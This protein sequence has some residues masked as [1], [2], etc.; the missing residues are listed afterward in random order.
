MKVNKIDQYSKILFFFRGS[1]PLK[2]GRQCK[3]GLGGASK[4]P[5]F[6]ARRSHRLPGTA[7]RVAQLAKVQPHSKTDLHE[8]F[9]TLQS[10]NPMK[11]QIPMS[12]ISRFQI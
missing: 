5:S 10:L 3:E 9:P 1:E 6:R 8:I 2:V 7:D 11:S 4:V 12:L